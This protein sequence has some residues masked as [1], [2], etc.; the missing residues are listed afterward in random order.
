[1]TQAENSPVKI[2]ERFTIAIYN[3]NHDLA[4]DLVSKEDRRV[5]ERTDEYP[6]EFDT[7]RIIG[8]WVTAKGTL[9]EASNTRAKVKVIRYIPKQVYI[10]YE[11]YWDVL[12]DV[13]EQAAQ[14]HVNKRLRDLPEDKGA[15]KKLGERILVLGK[16]Q[17]AWVV[18][19]GW[20]E[21]HAAGELADEAKALTPDGLGIGPTRYT[22][23]EAAEQLPQLKQAL[24]KYRQ[25]VQVMAKAPHMDAQSARERY[26]SRR[27]DLE[28]AI[29]NAK[30]FTAYRD[31]IEIRHLSR[32]ESTTGRTGLFGEVKNTGN[33]TVTELHVRFYFVNQSGEPV[34]EGW[35]TNAKNS[36][37]T[38]STY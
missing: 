15:P 4:I 19:A 6:P 8:D 14:R 12:I 25:A 28:N 18:R 36:A 11:E 38:L 10:A 2:A 27:E 5:A 20:P 22:D 31:K 32:G 9:L 24:E 33:R 26:Q 23:R 30:A 16:Q 21:L 1:M 35:Q 3:T 34:A 17:G 37:K 13:G 7:A 29:T